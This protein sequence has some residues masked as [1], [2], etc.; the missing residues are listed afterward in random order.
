MNGLVFLG[1][2]LAVVTLVLML[3]N[4]RDRR[5]A[6]AI[7]A[8]LGACPAGLRGSIALH[9]RGS[10]LSRRVMLILDLSDCDDGDVWPAVRVLAAARPPRVALVVATRLGATLPVAVRVPARG[11]SYPATLTM[12]ACGVSGTR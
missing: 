10:L 4:A 3:L 6:G 5:R 9:G 8:V 2:V 12:P 1:L 7:A 11:G